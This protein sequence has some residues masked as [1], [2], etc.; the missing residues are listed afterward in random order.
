MSEVVI[1]SIALM[2]ILLF[3]L[4]ANVTRFRVQRGKSG[5]N[6]QPTDPGDPMLVAIRAH[7]NAAE[8]VPTLA[9]LLVVTSI[10]VDGWWLDALA[11]AAVVARYLHG[12]GMLASGSLARRTPYKE[13]GALLTY[14]VGLALGVTAL[15]A[16]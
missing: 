4:G 12:I 11:I 9:V 8:Y 14:A 7:G 16:R 2:G 10:F 3:V 15:V 6:Q 5:G 13:A 1:T